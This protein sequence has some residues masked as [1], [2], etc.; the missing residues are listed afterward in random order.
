MNR[1]EMEA[2]VR[3][4]TREVVKELGRRSAPDSGEAAGSGCSC[5]GSCRVT[6]V[7]ED[8]PAGPDRFP[9]RVL[10]EAGLESAMHVG[11]TVLTLSAGTIVT[12]LARDRA[13]EIGIELRRSQAERPESEKEA[14]MPPIQCPTNTI[15]FLSARHSL[16]HERVIT[17]AAEQAG[18]ETHCCAAAGHDGGTSAA[19]SCARLVSEG[20]CCRGIILSDE[21][22]SVLRQANRMGGVRA[23]VCWDVERARAI[24]RSDTNLLLLSDGQLGLRMLERILEVWLER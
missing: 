23:A 2:L 13:A 21:V 4:V 20:Q 1:E 12:P 3:T 6:A 15:A 5:G 22:Y 7:G 18:F 16:T 9:G 8:S 14:P 10:T 17:D 19:L 24:R 11:Q